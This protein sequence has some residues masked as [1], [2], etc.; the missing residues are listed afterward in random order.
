M[1]QLCQDNLHSQ[2]IRSHF[3]VAMN[4]KWQN[5]FV[6]SIK[7]TFMKSELNI[8]VAARAKGKRATNQQMVR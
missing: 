7:F 3:D 5:L 8:C 1:T 4:C 6:A 2:A